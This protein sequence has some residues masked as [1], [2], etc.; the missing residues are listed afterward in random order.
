MIRAIQGDITKIT[1]FQAVVNSAVNS[2]LGGGGIDG[3][4]HRV[5]GPQ[6]R[7]ECRRLNGCETGDSRLTLG[8]NMPCDY[9]IHAVG[10]V[11]MGGTAGEEELL[12]ACY[13]SALKLALENNLRKI[14]FCAISSGEYGYPAEMA[15]KVAIKA[16][17][18]FLAD[19]PEAFDDICFVIPDEAAVNIYQEEIKEMTPKKTEVKKKKPVR[20]TKSREDAEETKD[21]EKA[22]TEAEDDTEK[23][24]VEADDDSENAP[25]DSDETEESNAPDESENESGEDEN[26]AGDSITEQEK[27]AEPEGDAPASEGEEQIE[28]GEEGTSEEEEEIPIQVPTLATAIWHKYDINWLIDEYENN[29]PHTYKCFWHESDG[30]ENSILSHWY[31]GKLIFINGIKYDTV[32][33]YIMS[34]KALLFGDIGTYNLIMQEKDPSQCKKY[35]RNVQNYDEAAWNMIFKEVIFHGYVGKALSD[36]EFAATLLKTGDS[37]LIEASPFDDIYGAGLKETDLLNEDGTLKVPPREWHAYKS[38][39]QA[40]NVL[41]FVLMAVRDYIKMLL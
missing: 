36:E 5:A 27:E 32:E 40:E 23:A 26:E 30:S 33:Q 15:S 3:Q 38:E 7:T 20:K 2:L 28:N 19:N 25:A 10:P 35:G 21:A 22:L 13:L 41:G 8:Y 4:I 12:R 37:V 14:A 31:G 18:D 1:G 24:P 16:I 39:R 29:T 6:L 34:E 9:I 17:G 11:W